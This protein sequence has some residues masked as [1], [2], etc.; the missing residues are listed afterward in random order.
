MDNENF[1]KSVS[2]IEFKDILDKNIS[3][4]DHVLIDI[5]TNM[6]Y[7]MGYIENSILLDLY[8]SNFQEE[9]NKLDKN[10]I[11][12]IYCRS[13]SRTGYVLNLMQNLGFKKVY[14]L[15]FGIIDWI[16]NGFLLKRK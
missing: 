5:R 1:F 16:K 6:E 11:Y 2:A 4:N 3:N 7:N 10:K 12:L 13:G 8:S 14:N 15:K 9:L